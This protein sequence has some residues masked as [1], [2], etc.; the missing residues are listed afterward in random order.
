MK[1]FG[2]RFMRLFKQDN[3]I[4]PLIDQWCKWQSR[5]HDFS[6]ALLQFGNSVDEELSQF[7]KSV[8]EALLQSDNSVDFLKIPVLSQFYKIYVVN[9]DYPLVQFLRDLVNYADHRDGLED[10]DSADL[11]EL[12][13]KLDQSDDRSEF[14][15]AVDQVFG[16]DNE[17]VLSDFLDIVVDDDDCD[18]DDL[19]DL[20]EAL[21]DY[22]DL[23]DSDI[24]DVLVEHAPDTDL[25]RFISCF[26]SFAP[27][28]ESGD[29]TLLSGL[30]NL[31]SDDLSIAMF[32]D[33]LDLS[34]T[35]EGI[36]SV[37]W[38]LYRGSE[39]GL[40]LLADFYSVFRDFDEEEYS[41]E[42]EDVVKALTSLMD[43]D[44]HVGHFVSA[45]E[46]D[47]S[48]ASHIKTAWQVYKIHGVDYN[49]AEF[50]KQVNE[51]GVEIFDLESSE[52][53]GQLFEVV[54]QEGFSSRKFCR[55]LKSVV[56]DDVLTTATTA[57]DDMDRR[58]RYN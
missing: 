38:D 34:F 30:W 26:P 43:V 29:I 48:N 3:V 27:L 33:E 4:A 20:Y 18:D 54:Q 47:M 21:D 17:D 37:L 8:D 51:E 28:I 36:L 45:F 10:I 5:D 49:L 40:N 1:I 32:A 42:D 57:E 31:A 9:L 58:Y 22:V 16:L 46:L 41:L 53:I 55:Q 56:S 52:N 24:L 23:L 7:G 39:S 25:D 2:V 12:I 35:D 6:E 13:W 50:V 11:M 44:V 14:L 19:Y 15:N